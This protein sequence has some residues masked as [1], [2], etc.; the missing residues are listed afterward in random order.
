MADR[1]VETVRLTYREHEVIVFHFQEHS[2]EW[3]KAEVPT[4][5]AYVLDL[6]QRE[7]LERIK[8]RVNRVLDKHTTVIDVQVKPVWR[9]VPPKATANQ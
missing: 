2:R 6:T 5:N 9:N 1:F 8:R 3:W 7:A 4:L